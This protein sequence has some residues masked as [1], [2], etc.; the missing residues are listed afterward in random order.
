MA[1]AQP[2][3][4][5]RVEIWRVLAYTLAISLA[6]VGLR[7]LEVASTRFWSRAA[8]SPESGLERE[9]A[10][11]A[12]SS[13]GALQ[14]LPDTHRRAAFRLGYELGF[15]SKWLGGF[16][17]SAVDARKQAT[18]L[19]EQHLT[20][21]RGLASQLG[22]DAVGVLPIATAAEFVALTRRIESD[23]NGL[24]GLIERQLSLHHRHLYLLGMH[25]GNDAARVEMTRG[26]VVPD[27]EPLIRYHATVAG[28]RP[29]LWVPLASEPESETPPQVLTRYRDGLAALDQSLGVN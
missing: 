1:S 26:T 16:A 6:L 10:Q 23:E 19:A 25:I 13:Q 17:L 2:I 15:A 7:R 4:W 20:V 14:R 22:L 28:I 29:N 11:V 18:A 3:R 9:A 27:M 5:R 8:V 21:A 12:Q 24:A